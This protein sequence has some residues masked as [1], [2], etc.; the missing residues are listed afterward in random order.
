MG[1]S[2]ASLWFEHLKD[3]DGFIRSK[4]NGDI[5]MNITGLKKGQD[6]GKF[7][8]HLKTTVFTYLDLV[9]KSQEDIERCIDTEFRKWMG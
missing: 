6:L 7:I 5:V 2:R 9:V 4:F 8:A 3:Q 1:R